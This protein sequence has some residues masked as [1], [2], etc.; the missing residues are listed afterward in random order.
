MVLLKTTSGILKQSLVMLLTSTDRKSPH[1]NS[2]RLKLNKIRIKRSVI[3]IRKRT[4]RRK[5]K[6]LLKKSLRK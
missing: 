4:K 6:L 5:N 3:R 1:L 2:K